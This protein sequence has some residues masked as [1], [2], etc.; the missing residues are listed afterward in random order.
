MSLPS[1]MRP[2]YFDFAISKTSDSSV[3]FALHELRALSVA[4]DQL[5]RWTQEQRLANRLAAGENP[6]RVGVPKS[7]MSASERAAADIHKMELRSQEAATGARTLQVPR[8]ASK[9]SL[10]TGARIA[11]RVSLEEFRADEMASA[12]MRPRDVHEGDAA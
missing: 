4:L 9:C 1:A 11:S 3:L 2:E 7:V 5:E 8:A 12:G 6:K 10:T